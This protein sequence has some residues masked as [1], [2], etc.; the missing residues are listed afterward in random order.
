[1]SQSITA[2][3]TDDGPNLLANNWHD[4]ADIREDLPR[5]VKRHIGLDLAMEAL[6]DTW[7]LERAT[8]DELYAAAK[9]CRVANVMRPYLEFVT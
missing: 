2:T 5:P 7:R 4:G 9:V 8:M 6:R 3:R 1:M